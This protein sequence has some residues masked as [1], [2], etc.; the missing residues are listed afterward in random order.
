MLDKI[1]YHY[2]VDAYSMRQ[3][4]SDESLASIKRDLIYLVK[5]NRAIQVEMQHSS[6]VDEMSV[7]NVKQ[8][9]AFAYNTYIGL[10][11]DFMSFYK[12]VELMDKFESF[13][14]DSSKMLEDISLE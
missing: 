5:M 8:N 2:D 1:K 14:K 7:I 12:Q 13:Y 9:L 3:L 6:D 11:C 4:L 10:F